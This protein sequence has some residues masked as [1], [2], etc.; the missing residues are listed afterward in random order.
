MITTSCKECRKSIQRYPSGMLL[1]HGPFCSRD[2]LGKY[3]TQYLTGRNGANFKTGTKKDRRYILAYSPWHPNRD[4]SGYVYL[5]RLIAEATIQRY[6]FPDEVVHHK[7][8]N[9]ENNHFTNLQIMTQNEH[10]RL[11]DSLRSK[12]SITFRYV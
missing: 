8:G 1:K 12:D 3:R 9:P 5:H 2:C 11:H 6:L 7:D 10:A 4:E